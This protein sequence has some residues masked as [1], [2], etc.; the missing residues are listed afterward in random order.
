MLETVI[1]T[2]VTRRPTRLCTLLATLRRTASASWGIDLPYSA[3]SVRSMA[4]SSW[5]T[6]TETPWVW[7]PLA[8]PPVMLP[9]RPLTAWEPPLPI[10]M[11]ST[12]WD[13][14]PA[15]FDTTLSEMLVEPRSVCS[16]LLCL[17]LCSLMLLLSSMCSVL[18]ALSSLGRPACDQP[19]DRQQDYRAQGRYENGPEAYLSYPW[20]PE[21]PL[22]YETAYEC[23]RYTDQDSDYDSPGV[24]P[25]HNPLGQYAGYESD[26]YQ[27]YYAYALSPPPHTLLTPTGRH[28]QAQYNR[29][30]TSRYYGPSYPPPCTH[31]HLWTRLCSGQQTLQRGPHESQGEEQG[32]AVEQ[33]V[34]LVRPTAGEFD[35]DVGDEAEAYAVR[36]VEGQRQRQDGQEGR[37]GLIETLPRDEPD[38]GHH[39]EAD[40]Y[41]GGGGHGRDE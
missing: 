9:R 17:D 27:R 28:P 30:R 38:G 10:L 5:P 29:C 15:I 11:P 33:R 34:D 24:R 1:L 22:H 36:D 20:A 12:S 4:A 35:Q 32:G 3:V 40:H 13:A 7:L 14:I 2:S 8:L 26:H 37:D 18:F 16:G 31:K 39:Q 41:E 23:S 25:W 19:V 6:S 21:E